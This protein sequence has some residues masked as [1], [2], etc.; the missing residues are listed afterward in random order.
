MGLGSQMGRRGFSFR[1]T[2]IKHALLAGTAA[3]PSA[4]P[5]EGEQRTCA[6][7]TGRDR[8]GVPFNTKRGERD[9]TL[10]VHQ[11]LRE[12]N[13]DDSHKGN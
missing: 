1:H 6:R 9:Y 13:T 4:L 7:G 2:Q 11:L 10:T 12:N 5:V 8:G 3:V